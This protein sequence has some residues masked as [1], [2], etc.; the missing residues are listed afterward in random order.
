LLAAK[1]GFVLRRKLDFVTAAKLLFVIR[2]KR[3][4]LAAFLR[5]E[6]VRV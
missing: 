4:L 5:R 1:L 2:K 6:R 3:I